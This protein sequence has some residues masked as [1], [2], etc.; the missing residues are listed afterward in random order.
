[1]HARR[2][3]LILGSRIGFR[4]EK[5]ASLIEKSDAQCGQLVQFSPTVKAVLV[6]VQKDRNVAVRIRQGITAYL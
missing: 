5:S 2:A 6:A 1:M 3:F 4:I